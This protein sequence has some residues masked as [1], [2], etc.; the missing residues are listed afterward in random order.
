MS[1]P[2]AANRS[3]NFNVNNNNTSLN[4]PKRAKLVGENWHHNSS[5]GGG[6][7]KP[8]LNEMDSDPPNEDAAN[9]RATSLPP[10]IGSLTSRNVIYLDMR[11]RNI[12]MDGAYSVSQVIKVNHQ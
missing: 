7:T 2:M 1:L 5:R 9:K 3:Q 6:A 8:H 4:N 11:N 10:N 12:K